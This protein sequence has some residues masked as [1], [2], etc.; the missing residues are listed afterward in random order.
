MQVSTGLSHGK[1]LFYKY[2]PSSREAI[3]FCVSCLFCITITA[4]VVHNAQEMQPMILSE[5]MPPFC[6]DASVATLEMVC[7]VSVT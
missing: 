2:W 7:F 4:F 1:P 6:L 3:V 5:H